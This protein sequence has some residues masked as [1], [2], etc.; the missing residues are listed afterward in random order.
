MIMYQ[1]R[2]SHLVPN[3]TL[4]LAKYWINAFMILYPIQYKGPRF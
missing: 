3:S 4:Y 2:T 1:V